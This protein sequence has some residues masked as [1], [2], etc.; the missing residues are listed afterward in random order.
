MHS[1]LNTRLLTRV[2][3]KCFSL[4]FVFVSIIFSSCESNRAEL[5]VINKSSENISFVNITLNKTV[6]K[7]K[8]IKIGSSTSV[9][10]NLL[11]DSHYKVSGKYA[12]GKNISMEFGY[13]TS[14]I[15][16]T[17]TLKI[18]DDSK[19]HYTGSVK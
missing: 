15:Q 19:Y 11:S 14:G 18:Y 6:K 2:V 4:L 8:N 16:F 5:I 13:V 17:D 3:H 12:S 1:I 10:F 7:V 9:I